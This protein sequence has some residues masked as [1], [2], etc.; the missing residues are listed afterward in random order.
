MLKQPRGVHSPISSYGEI[1]GQILPAVSLSEVNSRHDSIE[2]T[3]NYQG[4]KQ[5][6]VVLGL[7]TSTQQAFVMP[8]TNRGAHYDKSRIMAAGCLLVADE[9]SDQSYELRSGKTVTADV[10]KIWDMVAATGVAKVVDDWRP[11]GACG[12]G[13]VYAGGVIINQLSS[14]PKIGSIYSI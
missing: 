10:K 4:T 5:G 3:V 13:H 14:M 6:K 8:F 12:M 11:I 2:Y 9:F 1:A 7:L